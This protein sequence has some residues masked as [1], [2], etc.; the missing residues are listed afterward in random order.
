VTASTFTHRPAVPGETWRYRV[1]A[2]S[3]ATES[4]PS[5]EVSVVIPAVTPNA[6]DELAPGHWYEVPSS[7]LRGSSA[8]L[9]AADFPWLGQGEGLSGII[10]DWSSGAFDTQR[11]RLYFSGGGHNGYFGNEVYG[12]DLRTLAWVRLTNPDPVTGECPA[13]ELGVNCATHTYDGLEYLPPP[14][15]RFMAVGW[16]GWHQSTPT[17]GRPTPTSRRRAPEP[18]RTAPTT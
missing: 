1:T 3:D 9:T 13:R 11:D 4:A 8:A 17:A 2:V 7:K 18:V 12:F 10:N 6:I 14:F 16:D 15:D 5:N